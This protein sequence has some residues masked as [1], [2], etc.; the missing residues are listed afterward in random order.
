MFGLKPWRKA[1]TLPRLETP[2]GRMF[3]EFPALFNRMLAHLPEMEMPEWPYPWGVTTEEKEKEVAIRVEVPGFEAAEL[4]VE[5]TPERLLVEAEHKEPAEKAE[6]EEKGG[7]YAHVKREISLPLGL[8][9]EKAE[10]LYRNGVLEIRIP[11]KE[12][13]IGRRLEVKT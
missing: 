11:R 3:E 2:F 4:K 6:K 8:E 13:L 7:E 1:A 5:V 9:V 12:E 10:A